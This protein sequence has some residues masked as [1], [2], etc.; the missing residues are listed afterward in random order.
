[1]S[2]W[3]LQW[4]INIFLQDFELK[5]TSGCVQFK[6][7]QSGFHSAASSADMVITYFR[8]DLTLVAFQ[9]EKGLWQSQWTLWLPPEQ[10]QWEVTTAVL[11]IG[12]V[13]SQTTCRY[14]NHFHNY[15]QQ[16]NHTTMRSKG[17]T[18]WIW[19]KHVFVLLAQV[20]KSP[21]TRSWTSRQKGLVD[22]SRPMLQSQFS[23][24]S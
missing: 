23:V 4:V 7:F 16:Y 13:T 3:V 10:L 18:S 6:T 24:R 17:E 12:T 1:M 22:I 20:T 9:W 8:G 14:A 19:S 21:S 2:Q 15:Y 11:K 5:V